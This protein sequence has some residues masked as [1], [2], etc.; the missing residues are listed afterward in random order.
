MIATRHTVAPKKSILSVF[1]DVALVTLF[2]DKC[3]YFTAVVL[4]KTSF[5]N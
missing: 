3:I 1:H 5:S 2:D 4:V